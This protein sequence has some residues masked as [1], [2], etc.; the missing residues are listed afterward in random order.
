MVKSVVVCV[1][2]GRL[3]DPGE[4]KHLDPLKDSFA[5][6][7]RVVHVEPPA[8]MPHGEGCIWVFHL[9]SLAGNFRL[10]LRYQ[11]IVGRTGEDSVKLGA[12]VGSATFSLQ[13]VANSAHWSKHSHRSVSGRGSLGLRRC[14]RP[15]RR[16]HS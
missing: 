16:T 11:L 10:Y 14:A 5:R 4:E 1:P 6:Q 13:T 15:S 12:V 9:V 8:A 2:W 7:V 3:G